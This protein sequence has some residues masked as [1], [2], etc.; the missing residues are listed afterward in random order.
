MILWLFGEDLPL[1]IF[2]LSQLA[3]V[4]FALIGTMP[5]DGQRALDTKTVKPVNMWAEERKLVLLHVAVFVFFRARAEPRFKDQ[6]SDRLA[7][8]CVGWEL[9]YIAREASKLRVPNPDIMYIILRPSELRYFSFQSMVYKK[10]QVMR[11]MLRSF[12]AWAF[13]TPH[14]KWLNA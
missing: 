14:S 8:N 9:Y 1:G 4:G 7:N 12:P 6:Q 13:G 10:A 5:T 2:G 3:Q 11:A